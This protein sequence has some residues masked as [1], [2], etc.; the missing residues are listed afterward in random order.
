MN[1]PLLLISQRL[2][3]DHGNPLSA[4]MLLATRPGG[5][6]IRRIGVH[7]G[8]AIQS[9]PRILIFLMRDCDSSLSTQN[10]VLSQLSSVFVKIS[11][12]I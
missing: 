4:S 11:T 6:R 10:S 1:S 8:I 9:N 3:A 7:T 12:T 5:R 2:A